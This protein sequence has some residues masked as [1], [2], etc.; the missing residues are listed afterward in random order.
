MC[1]GWAYQHTECKHYRN[2]TRSERC[3]NVDSEGN[4]RAGAPV[5]T[6]SYPIA[7]PGLC[8]E[9]YRREEAEIFEIYNNEIRRQQDALDKFKRITE[10][11]SEGSDIRAQA[12][13]EV[14]RLSTVV[15]VYRQQLAEQLKIFRKRQGVWG[16]G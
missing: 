15:I 5:I 10:K 3:S 2:F 14:S 13:S 11:R 8:P 7:A 9:C 6:A 4:C 16:D 12:A 1:R